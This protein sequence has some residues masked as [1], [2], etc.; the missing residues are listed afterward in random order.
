MDKIICVGKNY[1]D[2]AAEMGESVPENPMIFLKPPSTLLQSPSWNARIKCPIPSNRG[3]VHYE[4][5]LVFKLDSHAKPIAATIGIDLTLR[6]LQA[7]LKKKAHPWTLSK[8]FHNS[9]ILGP[10]RELEYAKDSFF[11]DLNGVRKQTGN[12]AK[13]IYT[14][15]YLL[16]FL[17]TQF[18]LSEGDLLFTGTPE[19]IGPV[20]AG[21]IIK[22]GWDTSH[23]Y[24][25]HFTN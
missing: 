17:S 1:A 16:E 14:P 4:C 11:L 13:M 19:G 8:V 12:P 10:W 6:T 2:H 9:A 3:Q 24:E 5:E 21:D 23:S 18:P 25:V 20:V 22:L 7:E 15:D